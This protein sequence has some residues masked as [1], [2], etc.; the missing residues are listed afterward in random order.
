MAKSERTTQRKIH[1]AA[2]ISSLLLI[3]GL[4]PV[5]VGAKPSFSSYELRS[6][7]EEILFLDFDGDH[8]DDVI[9]IDEPNLVFFFQDRTHGFGQTPHLIYS[10]RDEPSIMWPAKLGN[11]PD[12]KILV[13]THDGVST[14]A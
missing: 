14:L 13:M 9:V 4:S 10:L 8:L 7:C 11:K 1:I 12:E 2:L 3:G 5:A 6:K